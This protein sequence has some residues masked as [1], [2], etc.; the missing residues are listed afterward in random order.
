MEL[1]IRILDILGFL[2]E[3][4]AK[5]LTKKF[6]NL[7]DRA[8]KFKKSHDSY[9]EIQEKPRIGNKKKNLSHHKIFRS[10]GK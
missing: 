1:L 4:L 9:Q 10:L 5:T 7:Q 3:N 8:K 6:K 2:G